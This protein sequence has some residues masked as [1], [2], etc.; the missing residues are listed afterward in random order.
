MVG[1]EKCCNFAAYLENRVKQK[2][3]SKVKKIMAREAKQSVF[4][5]FG[6]VFE[7]RDVSVN[8][9]FNEA[10]LDFNV[11]T[12][13]L[14][15]VP[16]NVMDLIK[17][18]IAEGRGVDLSGW[19]PSHSCIID[20]HKATLREDT[21]ETFGVV[22]SGYQ[23][24]QNVEA[25]KFVDFIG[26]VSG[27]SPEIIS[28]GALG[29]GERIFITA[30]V[31]ED[32]MLSE[33]DM[34]TPY[35]V[36]TTSHDGGGAVCAMVTPIRVVC[37]NTLNMALRSGSSNKIMFKHTKNVLGKLDFTTEENRQRARKV[38][39]G[40]N[41]FS[42][43]FL[44]AMYSL[45]NKSVDNEYAKRFV[46]K[47]LMN[48]EQFKLWEKANLNTETL[49]GDKVIGGKM[50]NMMYGIEDAIHNGIGQFAEY[51]GSALY[52]L[53]GVTTYF[54]NNRDE[55]YKTAEDKFVSMS[56]GN[57]LKY[58]QKAYDLLMVG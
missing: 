45:K 47:L 41:A 53:N 33:R 50:A 9:A 54:N 26:E 58:T 34:I 36:F 1:S 32:M 31:G 42:K 3:F 51:E 22:G 21:N 57:A 2:K 28:A 8:E 10:G 56:E 46:G 23:V 27:S 4:T 7:G 29:N 11:G 6:T 38:F 16:D 39:E 40:A 35:I 43:K 19:T 18:A 55:R 13:Q 44:D 14:L 12:Q 52:L 48:D 17:E 37:Q 20:S 49:R 5:S 24:V 15:R 30:K 25:L